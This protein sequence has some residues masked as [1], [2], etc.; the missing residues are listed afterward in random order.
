MTTTSMVHIR[1][2]NELKEQSVKTLN[3][4]GLTVS[5]AVRLFLHRVVAE[6]AIPFELKVPNAKTRAAMREAEEIVNS[7]H[8]RFVTAEEL[9]EDL[10]KISPK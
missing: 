9:F 5:D 6:Q 1:M 7:R 2:D 8:A 3:A 10:E 4:M